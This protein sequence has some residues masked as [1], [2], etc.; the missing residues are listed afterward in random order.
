[1]YE[2]FHNKEFMRRPVKASIA[3]D[4]PASGRRSKWFVCDPHTSFVRCYQRHN[5]E[6]L[7]LIRLCA[8]R[9]TMCIGGRTYEMHPGD[10]AVANPYMDHISTYERGERMVYHCFQFDL[11]QFIAAGET[12]AAKDFSRFLSGELFMAEFLPAATPAAET[13]NKEL[14]ELYTLYKQSDDS[15][16]SDCLLMGKSYQ[17]LALLVGAPWQGEPLKPAGKRDLSFTRRVADYVCEHYREP[18]STSTACEALSYNINHFCRLFHANFG[19]SFSLYL[20]EY[21]VQQAVLHYRSSNLS[22]SEIAQAVGFNDY[23]YFARSFRKYVG[24]SPAAYFRSR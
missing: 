11:R 15:L 7:E 8:G 16:I 3:E 9:L 14:D 4:D 1:M 19:S 6:G 23:G 2:T 22:I 12:S 5:H 17:V 20:C 13:L 24:F 10:I 21:R 18:I